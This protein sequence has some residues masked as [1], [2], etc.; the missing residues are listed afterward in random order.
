MMNS[1]YMIQTAIA[2]MPCSLLK[3]EHRQ[4]SM[5]DSTHFHPA[6]VIKLFTYLK[7]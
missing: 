3:N 7:Q 2:V 4:K 6:P 5:D 1:S